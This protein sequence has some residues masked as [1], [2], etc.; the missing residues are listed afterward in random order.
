MSARSIHVVAC[1]RISFL[2][3]AKSYFIVRLYHSLLIHSS[4][5][6]HLGCS[7][8]LA[9]VSLPISLN[10]SFP[11]APSLQ[12]VNVPAILCNRPQR[13]LPL[14]FH[15]FPYPPN[16]P[17]CHHCPPT[18]D[19]PLTWVRHLSATPWKL[20]PLSQRLASPGPFSQVLSCLQCWVLLTTC[21]SPLPGLCDSAFA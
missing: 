10:S 4:T 21:S 9:L 16:N 1:V 13:P 3:K 17:F 2:F 12:S 5:E 14:S 11:L 20:L 19:F 6:G 18:T 8:L 15:P 7:H